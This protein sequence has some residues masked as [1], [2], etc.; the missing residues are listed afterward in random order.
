[1]RAVSLFDLDMA[2]RALM[3]V[4]DGNDRHV[5]MQDMLD[6]AHLADRIRKGTG[7]SGLAGTVGSLADVARRRQHVPRQDGCPTDYLA[8]LAL[9]TH[10]IR[11]WRG[12]ASRTS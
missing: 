9:V 8:A 4:P 10:E 3:A 12:R 5:L 7:R 2:A 1:M 6:E 11:S